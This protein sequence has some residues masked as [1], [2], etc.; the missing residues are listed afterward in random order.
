MENR[1][2]ALEEKVAFLEESLSR[3]T[4]TVEEMNLQF[5]GL[6]KDVHNIRRTHNLA[7]QVDTEDSEHVGHY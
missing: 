2:K 6:K 3:L 1:T 5:V 4:K 7:E